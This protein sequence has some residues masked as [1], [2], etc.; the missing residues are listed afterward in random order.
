L[1]IYDVA[2]RSAIVTGG[3]SGIGA[4]TSHLLAASGAAVLVADVVEEHAQS[5]AD[6][7]TANGGTALAFA[8]DVADEAVSRSMVDR[9][10]AWGP[11]GSP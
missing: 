11:S 7:I 2:D 9:P 1:A 6:E 10:G 3:G 4:A 5:V 8:G